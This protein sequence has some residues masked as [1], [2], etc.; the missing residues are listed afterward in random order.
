MQK[1]REGVQVH[2]TIVPLRRESR[3]E[4]PLV[5][6]EGPDNLL[7]ASG[8]LWGGGEVQLADVRRALR[9]VRRATSLRTWP[10]HRKIAVGVWVPAIIFAV[11]QVTGP[12]RP[13]S[14][15]AA[16]PAPQVVPATPVLPPTTTTPPNAPLPGVAKWLKPRAAK[17]LKTSLGSPAALQRRVTTHW[18]IEGLYELPLEQSTPASTPPA[19][20]PRATPEP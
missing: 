20:T 16:R 19:T 2:P 8:G 7:P 9:R 10:L 13:T 11:A 6:A 5:R 14:T 18:R 12:N 3:E 1:V 15:P 4:R 17:R